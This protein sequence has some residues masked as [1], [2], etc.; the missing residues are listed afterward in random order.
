LRRDLRETF[1]DRLQAVVAHGP[2]IKGAVDPGGQPA[3]VSTLA[4]V[5]R[6][7]YKDLV[8]CAQR[9]ADW[10]GIGVNVP[11]LLS[12]SDF[13][14]SLDAFPLEYGDIIA[15]H[16]LVEGTD[17]FAGLAV[18]DDDVRRA[19][20]GWGKSHLIQLRE[21]FVEA[22]GDAKAVARLIV[23]SASPFAALLAHI[24]RLRGIDQRDP[25]ALA[26][27]TEGIAGLPV[28]PVREVLALETKPNLDG[29]TAMALFPGYLDAVERL[30]DFLDG[31][32][33]AR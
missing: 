19:C 7:T 11:L 29:D 13:E 18:R 20:E 33:K 1:G 3:A 30:A 9:A 16:V 27:V 25:D 2:R 6:V 17:P 32:T 4:L 23:A 14:R 5:D 24:V 22:R 31:W 21:G 26:H 10:H 28:A 12:R 8:A 15:N